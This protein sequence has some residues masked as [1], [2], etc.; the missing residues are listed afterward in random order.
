MTTDHVRKIRH[1]QAD[2]MVPVD[3]QGQYV[4]LNVDTLTTESGT[5]GEID[6][7]S[8]TSPKT[9]LTPS[10]GKKI[11]LRGLYLSTDSTNGTIEATFPTSNILIGKLYCSVRTRVTLQPIHL[12]GATDESI[13]ISWTGLSTGAKIFY[14]IRYKEV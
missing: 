12:Q 14:A 6:T 9:V 2:I 8:E 13:Q 4:T 5:T 7:S 1:A 11:D 10:S 3:I